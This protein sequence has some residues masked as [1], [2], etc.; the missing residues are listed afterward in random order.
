MTATFDPQSASAPGLLPVRRDQEYLKQVLNYLLKTP[1]GTSEPPHNRSCSIRIGKRHRG[2]TCRNADQPAGWTE[3]G[4]PVLIVL[5]VAPKSINDVLGPWLAEY[6]QQNRNMVRFLLPKADC[7]NFTTTAILLITARCALLASEWKQNDSAI[8]E[9]TSQ[10]RRC[11]EI[12]SQEPLRSAT[13]CSATWDFQAPKNCTFHEEA[14]GATGAD[15]PAAVEKHVT[16][17]HFAPED[18]EALSLKQRVVMR[19][20]GKF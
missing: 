11:P 15:I 17:N 13:L 8:R 3:R 14:H 1:D 9:A 6:V 10:I 20:C 18:F 2:Q 4:K 5:P 7:Q 19:P 12:R 16:D